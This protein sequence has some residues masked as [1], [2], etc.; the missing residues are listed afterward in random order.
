MPTELPPLLGEVVPTV[1][2]R[3]CCVV[4]GTD[5]PGRILGFQYMYYLNTLYFGRLY[6]IH[7]V[8]SFDDMIYLNYI[9]LS[10]LCSTLPK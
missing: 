3:G 6:T 4:S 10:D 1:V 2:D 7:F 9:V 5:P 8:S